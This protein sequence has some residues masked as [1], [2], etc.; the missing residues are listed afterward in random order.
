MIEEQKLL[1]SLTK[2]VPEMNFQFNRALE[3]MAKDTLTPTQLKI[4][5]SLRSRKVL[6][7]SRLADRLLISKPQLTTT[8]DG[9]VKLGFIERIF[10]PTDRRK[11]EIQLTQAG[12]DYC[13]RLR[14]QLDIYYKFCLS[15]LNEQE[16][17]N[18]YH[19]T[20]TI[21]EFITKLRQDSEYCTVINQI[22]RGGD[23]SHFQQATAEKE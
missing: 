12:L 6:S 23:P 17:E 9:L 8:V 21:H 3:V 16:Q 10:D 19:A 14:S 15:C 5:L 20:E 4:V 7:M 2:V 13:A 22:L 1:E 11:I 18:L